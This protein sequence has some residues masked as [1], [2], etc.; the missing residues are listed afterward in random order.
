MTSQWDGVC[1]LENSELMETDH[2]TEYGPHLSAPE[3]EKYLR[4]YASHFD[5]SKDIRFGRSVERLEREHAKSQWLLHFAD[6]PGAPQ[7]FD[8]VVWATGQFLQPKRIKLLDQNRFAGRIL[9]SQ[10]V[11][12]LANFEDKNVVVLGMGN[13]AADVAVALVS[14]AK[15]VYLS[16][17]RGATI[18]CRTDADG[19]PGDL[20]QSTTASVAMW[21]IE[22]YMPW[23]L[24]YIMDTVLD[25]S[26][27]K[28]YGLNDP[29]WGFVQKASIGDGVHTV[30]CNDGL[31][32]NVKAGKLLSKPMIKRIAGANS[33]ELDSGEVLD[34]IDVIITCTGY[35]NDMSMLSEAVTYAEPLKDGA[36]SLP[37]LY[38]NIFPPEHADSIAVVS[39][40]H[41]NAAQ[42]PARELTAMA[43][44]QIWA[45]NSTLPSKSEMKSWIEEHYRWRRPRAVKEP[46][47]HPGDLLTRPWMH[48]LHE[49][50]G[51]GM[52]EH[53]GWSTKAWKFWWNDRT[54]YNAL[55]HGPATSYGHRLFETG[56]RKTW[57]GARKAIL[58]VAEEVD[59]LKNGK[60]KSH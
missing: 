27:K 30:T 48:F 53:L 6:T 55:A 60:Q 11:R 37:N 36:S 28:K 46:N 54:L 16:H 31:I 50:A 52:L 2:R 17:R 24:G 39:F 41:V 22:Q 7:A 43:V 56:K 45:G 32:P 58:D 59:Q 10:D 44:A 35:A 42:P 5:L 13:T 23:L 34:G 1:N 20:L 18:M 26:F 47:L 4:A 9:H 19:L 51:T 21:W 8:K 40:T 57:S 14:H 33:V 38:M 12:N 25:A 15:Q 29:A 49:A 3:M